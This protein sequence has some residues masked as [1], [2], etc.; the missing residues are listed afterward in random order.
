MHIFMQYYCMSLD[1]KYFIG[2]KK[3]DVVLFSA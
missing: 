2:K 1:G 3:V